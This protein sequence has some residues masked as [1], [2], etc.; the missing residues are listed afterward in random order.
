MIIEELKSGKN[1]SGNNDLF[2]IENRVPGNYKN[3]KGENVCIIEMTGVKEYL[4]KLFT[5]I[6]Q[7]CNQCQK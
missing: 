6:N 7:S 4:D 2:N 1:E 3:E 5:L